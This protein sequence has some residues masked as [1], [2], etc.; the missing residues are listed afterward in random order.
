RGGGATSRA[1]PPASAPLRALVAGVATTKQGLPDEAHLLE[2]GRLPGLHVGVPADLG[3]R[4]C[5]HVALP[6]RRDDLTVGIVTRAWVSGRH[7]LCVIGTPARRFS[8]RRG[9][10]PAARARGRA[11]PL[12][13]GCAR[14]A[15]R[16]C[17]GGACGPCSTRRR[18]RTRSPAP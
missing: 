3:D 7:A 15:S 10:A 8:A 11:P 12:P 17:G 18:A 9:R 13:C 4:R 2:V 5:L 16:R 6:G 14:R 1:P